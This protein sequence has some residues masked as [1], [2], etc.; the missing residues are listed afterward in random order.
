MSIGF[1]GIVR[2]AYLGASVTWALALPLATLA[3]SQP[4]DA[5]VIYWATF[6]VYAIGRIICH[7]LPDRSFHLWWAQMPVCARC[8][9]IY[10]AAALT[11]LISVVARRLQPSVARSPKGF[12]LLTPARARAILALALLPTIATLLYEWTS[13]VTP[14]N[15]TRLVAGLPLGAAVSWIVIR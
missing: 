11:G 2:R 9:G 12:A 6:S 8:T 13:G 14:S 1:I 15:T 5:P 10:T 4:R 3:A 7:Q